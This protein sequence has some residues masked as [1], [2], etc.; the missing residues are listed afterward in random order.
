MVQGGPQKAGGG[1]HALKC[2]F[3]ENRTCGGALQGATRRSVRKGPLESSGPTTE[4][5]AGWGTNEADLDH[6]PEVV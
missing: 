2:C 4:C 6:L 5:L 3:K 1:A